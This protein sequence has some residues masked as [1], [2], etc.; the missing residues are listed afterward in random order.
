MGH[1]G[2]GSEVTDMNSGDFVVTADSGQTIGEAT[3]E[4]HTRQWVSDDDIDNWTAHHPPSGPL[5][6][7][8]HTTIR[9]AFNQVMKTMNEV[10]PES[11]DK[12][13]ALNTARDAMMLSNAAIAM[14][15]AAFTTLRPS[16][17][18]EKCGGPLVEDDMPQMVAGM[19][20]TPRAV[21]HVVEAA[22][23]HAPVV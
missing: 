21:R 6:I 20:N 16:M 22:D 3:I 17:M 11:P 18:C 12:T 15:Q 7:V 14:K 10:L 9:A 19:K 13:R 5:V 8:A 2:K 4:P 1:A 23:G